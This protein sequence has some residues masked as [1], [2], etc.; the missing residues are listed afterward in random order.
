MRLKRAN[1]HVPD[2]AKVP[3]TLS[4]LRPQPRA[5]EQLMNAVTQK[6]HSKWVGDSISFIRWLVDRY[7]QLVQLVAPAA[8]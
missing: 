2:D 8:R 5:T 6:G 7:S 3:K 1:Y 4:H